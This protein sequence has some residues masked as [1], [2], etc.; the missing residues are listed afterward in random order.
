[1][2]PMR[3]Q[4]RSN[5]FATLLVALLGATV[6]VALPGC[7][8]N[9][10]PSDDNSAVESE[11]NADK[12]PVVAFVEGRLTIDGK[13]VS[14]PGEVAH[15]EAALGPATRQETLAATQTEP[16]VNVY[17]WDAAGI[18]AVE[19][20]DLAHVTK[21]TF[22]FAPSRAKAANA[23]NANLLPTSAFPGALSIDGVS[24]DASTTPPK[25]N[26]K[27]KE[28]FGDAKFVA[29]KN[30]PH[31]WNVAYGAWTVT[32]ITDVKGSELLELSV[33]D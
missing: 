4:F 13:A 6:G 5:T 26:E 14:L 22:S 30:F 25:L 19:R 23:A 2:E 32:A 16:F 29:L 9:E 21:V 20:P 1:M 18:V 7:G 31:S 27:L 11:P 10:A 24:I 3:T 17:I 33:G 12:K 28:K 8:K 15:W